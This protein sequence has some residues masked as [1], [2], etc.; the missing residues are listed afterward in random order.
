LWAPDVLAS[1][2]HN[3]GGNSLRVF[4]RLK[5]GVSL[6]QARA[7][8]AAITARLEQQYPGT[9]RQVV[10]MPLKEKVVGDVKPALLVLLG[11][12]TFVFLI[13]C[14]NVAHMTLARSAARQREV[15]VRVALGARRSRVIRQ[16]ITES[17]LLSFLGAVAGL[18]LA[19]WGS[20]A[21]VK[22]S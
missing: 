4:A 13:A 7:E 10:V 15:A 21:L 17:L 22:L 1:R 9:N 6:E 5:P 12:V 14:A 18:L 16:F 19:K 2:V 20:A 11:A 8:M 3:R